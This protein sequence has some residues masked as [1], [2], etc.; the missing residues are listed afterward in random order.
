MALN[1]FTILSSINDNKF[2]NRFITQKKTLYPLTN[3]SSFASS[4]PC[5]L[6]TTSLISVFTDLPIPDF[7]GHVTK[8][9][10][11]TFITQ[12]YFCSSL[13]N[14]LY[15]ISHS[16]PRLLLTTVIKTKPDRFLRSPFSKPAIFS[17][18]SHPSLESS[19]GNNEW[20]ESLFCLFIYSPRT[21]IPFN[22]IQLP[23]RAARGGS[24]SA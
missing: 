10:I 11:K 18:P 20:T 9:W 23:S 5:S 7:S 3:H 16:S 12:S 15:K 8:S 14:T 22:L 17:L 2:Q 1:R 19:R 21:V 6:A 4:Q 13:Y 24:G